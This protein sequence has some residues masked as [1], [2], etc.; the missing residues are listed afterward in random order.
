MK[1]ESKSLKAGIER[2]LSRE[3]LL[4]GVEYPVTWELYPAMTCNLSCA[5]C[6]NGP[7]ARELA[8][9]PHPTYAL[10]ELLDFL[11]EYARPGDR[12]SFTGG[13]PFSRVK[14]L[15]SLVEA[16][17]DMGFIYSAY[18]NGTLLREAPPSL[19]ERFSQLNVSIDGGKEATDR[20]RG[21]GTF[22]RILG[23][24]EAV[25]PRF[26]GQMVA[27]MTVTPAGNLLESVRNL[28]EIPHFDLIY[29]QY[30]NRAA[31]DGSFGDRQEKELLSLLD[32]W[33][34]KLDEGKVLPLYPFISITG[35]LL[36]NRQ[37]P[38]F[39]PPF[40]PGCGAGYNYLQVFTT[41][42]LYACPELLLHEEALMGS[43]KGGIGRRIGIADFM[44][45]RS[46]N[47]C[48][49]FEICHARCLYFRPEEYCRLIRSA[50]RVLAERL[51]YIRSLIGGG[52]IKGGDF[53]IHRELEEI[54]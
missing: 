40:S 21:D 3:E 44:D 6:Y 4:G 50:V 32:F 10:A 31:L 52:G 12:I 16:T 49:A 13:E 7:R 11:R 18:T 37:Y 2:R 15:E 8:Q 33:L 20:A 35:K 29:W 34:E 30:Q 14:W 23:N 42:D 27:R 45:A 1:T 24:L 22:A 46:C 47:A 53:A 51:E 54:F 41:G 48:E 38:G 26:S 5:Y 25:R 36:G 17:A 28:L 9:T 43:L 19:L 39:P